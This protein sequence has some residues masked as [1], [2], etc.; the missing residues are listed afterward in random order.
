MFEFREW[1]GDIWGWEWVA[2]RVDTLEAVELRMKGG[3]KADAEEV[4]GSFGG[5]GRNAL[6]DCMT[7]VD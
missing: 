5:A 6:R 1:F 3:L 7:R 4:E 2:A